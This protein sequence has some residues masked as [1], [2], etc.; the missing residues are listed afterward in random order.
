M[1]GTLNETHRG[2]TADAHYRSHHE[3]DTV[4][5]RS[6]GAMVAL[7]L[8]KQ[9]KK[10]GD[11]PF[12]MVQSKT[13]GAPVVSGDFPCTNLNRI[14]WAGDPISALGFNSATVM[15]SSKQSFNDSAHD[16]S[17]VFIKDAVPIR[18]TPKNTLTQSPDDNKTEVITYE[19]N[20]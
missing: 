8:E 2:R 7:S 10:E 13:F 18:G 20:K 17:G 6:L 3:I 15:P 1:N 19:I 5:G 16:Y 14:R 4:I 11:N 12:V 9:C